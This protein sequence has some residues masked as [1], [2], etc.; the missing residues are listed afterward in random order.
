LVQ[1]RG[2]EGRDFSEREGREGDGRR[3]LLIIY[4]SGSKEGRGRE[5][6]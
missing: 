4:M 1:K 6:F 5:I 2:W 3:D